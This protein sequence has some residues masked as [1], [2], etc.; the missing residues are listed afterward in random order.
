MSAYGMAERAGILHAEARELLQLHKEHYRAFWTWAAQNVEYALAGGV[1]STPMGWQ[2]RQG[3]GTQPNDRSLLNW[4]M[5]STGADILRLSCVRLMEA[6]IKICAPVHDALLIEAPLNK[7]EEHVAIAQGIME[8]A[9]RD[10]LHGAACRVDA[11]II[12]Y[13]DRYM[14][15]KRGLGMWNTVMR[16]IGLPEFSAAA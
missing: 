9:C 13:P 11:D 1:L 3:H 2:F 6:G 5:Q 12:R 4:P 16:S 7:L 14:D 15:T 10:L 8:Q